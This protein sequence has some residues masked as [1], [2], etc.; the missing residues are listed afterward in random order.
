MHVERKRRD[1]SDGLESARH[2]LPL[3]PAND[4]PPPLPQTPP[5][6]SALSPHPRSEAA[7]GRQAHEIRRP[8]TRVDPKLVDLDRQDWCRNPA[9]KSPWS[10]DW[11]YWDGVFSFQDG[12]IEGKYNLGFDIPA[13]IEP[14][15]RRAGGLRLFTVGGKYYY[16]EERGVVVRFELSLRRMTRFLSGSRSGG[17]SRRRR[18]GG[19]GRRRCGRWRGG[20]RGLGATNESLV[21]TMFWVGGALV[22]W[23][24]I[25]SQENW[26]D[27]LTGAE[28]QRYPILGSGVERTKTCTREKPEHSIILA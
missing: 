26:V 19:V 2:P 14:L 24:G 4:A 22:D 20:H 23:S 15:G 25:V 9:V 7:R 3:P 18:F 5:I 6:R 1:D 27:C 10:C 21:Y 28:T 17:G 13:T 16:Y 11:R 8:A 12:L